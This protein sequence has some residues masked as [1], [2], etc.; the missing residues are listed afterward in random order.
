MPMLYS[1][2]TWNSFIFYILVVTEIFNL[3]SKNGVFAIHIHNGK[4]CTGNENDPFAYAGSHLNFTDTEHLF[5]TGDLPALFSNCGYSWI[6]VYTNRFQPFQVKGF[7]VIIHAY[8]DDFHS[9]PSGNSGKK[10]S[11]GLIK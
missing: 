8:S 9:Q 3:P 5:H 1:N 7:S 6:A 2:Y 4:S 10:I 11:C